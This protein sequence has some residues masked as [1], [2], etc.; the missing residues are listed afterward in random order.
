[1][2]NKKLI[3]GLIIIVVIVAYFI[4][5]D[6]SFFSVGTNSFLTQEKCEKETGKECSFFMCDFVPKGKTFEDVCGEFGKG[7]IPT[8]D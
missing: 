6:I 1:M 8:V 4:Q 3:V 5:K 2:M 7:W